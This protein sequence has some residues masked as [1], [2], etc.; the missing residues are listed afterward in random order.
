MQMQDKNTAACL[1]LLYRAVTGSLI[2]AGPQETKTHF[3]DLAYLNPEL[4]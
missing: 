2:V 4:R 3:S 1:V